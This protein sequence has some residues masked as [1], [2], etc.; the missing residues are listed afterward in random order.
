MQYQRGSMQ[1]LTVLVLLNCKW[2]WVER[3]MSGFTGSQAKYRH[4]LRGKRVCQGSAWWPCWQVALVLHYSLLHTCESTRVFHDDPPFHM[5]SWGC[6]QTPVIILR[7][8]EERRAVSSVCF[9]LKHVK[10]RQPPSYMSPY[11][12]FLWVQRRDTFL[13][14]T[15]C[16]QVELALGCV[17]KHIGLLRKSSY[18]SSIIW[19]I[20]SSVCITYNIGLWYIYMFNPGLIL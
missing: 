4:L 8:C 17:N 1:F 12:L 20:T 15:C 3:G 19:F 6:Q 13:I 2:Q 7:S 16:V 5:G 14:A 18:I 9:P 11:I 10:K